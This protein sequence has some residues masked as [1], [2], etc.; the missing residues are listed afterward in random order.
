[1]YQIFANSDGDGSLY[2]AFL[3]GAHANQMGA[4]MRN[5]PGTND[6]ISIEDVPVIIFSAD[7]PSNFQVARW[8]YG[9]VHC[10]KTVSSKWSWGRGKNKLPPQPQYTYRLFQL[11]VIIGPTYRC[12]GFSSTGV[13][14]LDLTHCDGAGGH[15]ILMQAQVIQI[16]ELLFMSN[17]NKRKFDPTFP[18]PACHLHDHDHRDRGDDDSPPPTPEKKMRV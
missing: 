9:T 12:V 13:P 17:G 7:N 4:W 2:I 1:M 8:T 5:D 18:T 15:W 11:G 3:A 6:T 10:D 14:R 16:T